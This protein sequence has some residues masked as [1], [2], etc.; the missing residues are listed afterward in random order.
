MKVSDERRVNFTSNSERAE[1]LMRCPLL[2]TIESIGVNPLPPALPCLA[3]AYA[4]SGD[5][6]QAR[7]VLRE[8]AR[9]HP[10]ETLRSF[11]SRTLV[12]Y[13]IFPRSR[14]YEGL[15]KAGLPEQ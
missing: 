5:D 11:K 8:F 2:V 7:I 14:V 13:Q 4:L 12:D 1:L 3:A 10:H 6:E 15:L 9:K